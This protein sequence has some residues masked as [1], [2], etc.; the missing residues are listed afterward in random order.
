MKWFKLMLLTA[1]GLA[2]F[3]AVEARADI[4]SWTDENGVRY[5]TNYAPP[6]QA[7]LLMKTPEIPYDAQADEQRRAND[8]LEAAKQQ[9]AEKEALLLQQQQEAE[10]RLA[11]ANAKAE[12]TLQEA[13]RILQDA[14]Q[15]A[16]ESA[17]YDDDN[18]YAY[19][20][21]Y[22]YYGYRYP[23]KVNY[24]DYK[25][26]YYGGLYNKRYPNGKYPSLYQRFV[27]K[28]STDRHADTFRGRV[29]SHQQRVTPFRGQNGRY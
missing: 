19:P 9:L 27:R 2:G 17:D 7:K 3:F 24:Y 26:Y 1:L 13:D 22:P 8:E 5:F 21:Y 20:Y 25:Y 11:E 23:P 29:P 18:S 28:F 12:A 15:T 16:G 6:K 10:R 4:Y 14:Q